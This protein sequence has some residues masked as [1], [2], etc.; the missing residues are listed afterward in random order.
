LPALQ[1]P[2]DGVAIANPAAGRVYEVSAALHL[3]DQGI[4][5]EMFGLRVQWSVDRDN[6]T[7]LNQRFDRRMV[8]DITTS[9]KRPRRRLPIHNF[10]E[11]LFLIF[12]NFRTYNAGK[13]VNDLSGHIYGFFDHFRLL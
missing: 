2:D 13:S 5:E 7:Y 10:Y 11:V 3:A 8:V 9:K 12:V 1:C 4:V 6:V